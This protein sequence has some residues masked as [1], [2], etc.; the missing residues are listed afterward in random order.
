MIISQDSM[1]PAAFEGSRNHGRQ[2]E[3]WDLVE[4]G[5]ALNTGPRAA[6]PAFPRTMPPLNY[7]P[8]S[9]SRA[10]AFACSFPRAVAWARSPKLRRYNTL[11]R[12]REAARRNPRKDDGLVHGKRGVKGEMAQ[13]VA[14][15]VKSDVATFVL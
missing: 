15:E 13:R 3:S 8:D 6:T 14:V 7:K 10:A 1:I 12:R 2:Q 4:S 5:F 9:S 11:V